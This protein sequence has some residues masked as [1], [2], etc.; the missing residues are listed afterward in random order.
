MAA[1]LCFNEADGKFLWQALH[2]IPDDGIF[3]ESRP[4]GL[5]S[6][7]CVEGAR[8]YYVTP[9][10]AVICADNATGKAIW[11]YDLMKNEKVIPYHC[12]N[13]SPLIVDDLLMIVTGNGT[14]AGAVPSPQAPSFMAL[15]KNTG[16]PAWRSNLP[17]DKII[18]GQWS[19]PA[20]AVVAGKKQVIFPGGDCWL[21]SLEPKTGKLLWK[22]NCNPTRGGPQADPDFNPYFVATPAVHDGRCYISL[23]VTPGD[24]VSPRN[25]AI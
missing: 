11:R 17:G 15:D 3:H 13:C 1:L 21:Y 24:H 25:T 4:F 10:C 6:N 19:N 12:G 23:G 5:L 16:K 2:E 7:P 22:F 20:V 18:E 8:H 14:D 9:A